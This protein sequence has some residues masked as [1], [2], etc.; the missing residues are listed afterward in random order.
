MSPCKH[1]FSFVRSDD[2]LLFQSAVTAF[3][4]FQSVVI[5]R[6]P[7][8]TNNSWSKSFASLKVIGRER[9]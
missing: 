7:L 6:Q 3:D 5:Y 1:A 9:A 4:P 2:D 8:A